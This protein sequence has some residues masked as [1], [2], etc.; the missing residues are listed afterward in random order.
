MK[1]ALHR[2]YPLVV[3]GTGGHA[4]SVANVAR[5]AGFS[6]KYF[7]DE[8]KRFDKLLGITLIGDIS[9]LANIHEHWFCIAVGD[10]AARERIFTQLSAKYS[11]LIFPSLIHSS[12]ILSDYTEIGEGTVVMPGAVVGPN[13]RIGKFC[14]LNTHSSIDHDSSMSDYSSLA[15]G[16]VTG[17]TVGI[18][19][20]S[21]ISI[22]AVIKH[23]I[24][25]G[26]DCVVGAN[27][28][29]DKDLSS[30][31]VA[32]GTPARVV[33]ERSVGDPYLR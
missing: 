12:A 2:V 24:K 33:R 4:I 17:G 19:V 6:V 13:S 30:C 32:Y 5:S 31:L 25:V 10:N 26:D 8:N 29:V 7:V 27:S 15:P 21:A 1:T 20:R 14:I 16:V 22:G 9:E 23:G 11:N 3:I 28:Y 18:G